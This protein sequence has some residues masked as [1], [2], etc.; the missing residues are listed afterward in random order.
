MVNISISLRHKRHAQNSYRKVIYFFK[1][2]EKLSKQNFQKNVI[3]KK[4]LKKESHG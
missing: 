3:A 1:K 2:R 4:T